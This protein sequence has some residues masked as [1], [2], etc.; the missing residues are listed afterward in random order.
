LRNRG[1]GRLLITLTPDKLGRGG[2]DPVTHRISNRL[3]SEQTAEAAQQQP[4]SAEPHCGQTILAAS[5]DAGV[6]P[7]A[8]E[9]AGMCLSIR[10]AL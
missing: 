3:I 8:V 5:T 6:H 4:S 7:R 1:N 9:S 10:P 2:Q